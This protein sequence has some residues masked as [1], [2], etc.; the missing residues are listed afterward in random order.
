MGWVAIDKTNQVLREETHGRPVQAGEEGNLKF[1]LQEDFN[2]KV[3]VDLI[4][5][6]IIIGYDDWGIQNDTVEIHNPRTVFYICDETNIIA[7][8]MDMQT[9][10]P[11]QKGNVINTFIPLVWRPIWFTRVSAG[12]PTKVIGAQTTLPKDYG[13]KNVKKLVSIFQSGALGID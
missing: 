5:G 12:Q 10:E 7:E 9:S 6:V 8:L 1:I 2:Q 3:A 13:S 11:D 4:N